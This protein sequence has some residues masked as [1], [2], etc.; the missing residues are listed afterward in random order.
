MVGIADTVNAP[1]SAPMLEKLGD[2]YDM[3][4]DI[5]EPGTEPELEDQRYF[6]MRD[7]SVAILV[8]R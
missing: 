8:G 7:R 4:V 6:L 1:L 5:Q 2:S 3:L